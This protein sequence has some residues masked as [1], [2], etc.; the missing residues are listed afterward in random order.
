MPS[1][2]IG[3][4]SSGS[5]NVTVPPGLWPNTPYYLLACANDT[6]TVAEASSGNCTASAAT[7][8]FSQP[9]L[10]TTTT[11][12]VA[13]AGN[14]VTS[15]SSG[16]VVTLTAAVV[17]VGAP[18]VTGQVNFCDASATY[19]TD[20]H[21]LGTAQLSSKGTATLKF[22]PGIGSHN[23]EAV[24]LGTINVVGSSS[25]ASALSVTGKFQ[26]STTIAQSGIPGNYT[27]AAAVA[28]YLCPAIATSPTGTVSF[29]DSS[30]NTFVLGETALVAGTPSLNWINSQTP[31]AG[32][33]PN[34]VAVGDFN[35]D[36]IPDL[37]VANWY[38][39]TV[40]ILLGN[41]NGTFT[42]TAV[43]PPVG[44]PTSVAVGDFNGD[45]KADLAVTS[46]NDSYVAIFLGNGD[47]TFT[48]KAAVQT[49]NLPWFVTVGDFNGD[50]IADLAVADNGNNTV[51]ILLG[52][53]DG[54]FAVA[55]SPEAGEAPDSIAVGDF[56]GDG[57]MDLAV[58]SSGFSTDNWAGAVT[59]LLGNGDG[60]F[61]KGAV[62]LAA[63]GHVTNAVTVGDF[64]GDGKPDLAVASSGSQTDNW[65]GAVTI[66]WQ[67]RRNVYRD[68]RDPGGR[69]RFDCGGRLQRGR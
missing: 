66:L 27:L 30:N 61:T 8:V 48:Y 63:V 54:T 46:G 45:G 38:G 57:R 58:T 24:F 37:A 22:L 19:C 20:I 1:L 69:S 11:L 62:I 34:S 56:N 59:I 12:A 36:G 7:T 50:G 2:A 29:L 15:V 26:T 14:P 25:S 52:N 42:A 64:S 60:T 3:A 68:S 67:W 32:N 21:L 49:G 43:S 9:R 23:Y 44:S 28:G 65:A 39:N 5:V 41:G 55:A 40:T 13:S 47:G 17:S 18:V 33:V 51:T 16:S 6:G 53:G 35:G 10:P 31:G 4:T